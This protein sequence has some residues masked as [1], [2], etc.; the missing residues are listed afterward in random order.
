[1]ALFLY[2]IV[3]LVIQRWQDAAVA[4]V[5]G[6]AGFYAQRRPAC[7]VVLAAALRSESFYNKAAEEG[8]LRISEESL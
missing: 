1:L 7:R 4:L 5:L 2:S 3:S 6:A 8:A